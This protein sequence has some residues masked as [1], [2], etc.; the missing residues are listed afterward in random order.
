[1]PLLTLNS[2]HLYV[3][4][5]GPA[6]APVL[7]YLH[8]GP[9]TGCYDFMHQQRE[10]LGGPTRLIALD[11]RGVLRSEP[12]GEQ[13]RLTIDDLLSD[14]EALRELLH[15]E[16]WSVLGHSFGGYLALQYALAFPQ[17]VERLLFENP[18]FDFTLSIRSLLTTASTLFTKD[19]QSDLAAQCHQTIA[20]PSFT[21]EMMQSFFH[22]MSELGD[23]HTALY[24]HRSEKK[25]F[26]T[27]VA[28]SDL[29]A[30]NWRRAQR[31]S[32][33]L[34]A[35]GRLTQE[36]L[37]PRLQELTCPTLL[38]QGAYDAVTGPEQSAAFH[39]YVP[40]GTIQTFPHSSHFIHLEEPDAFASAVLSFLL[41][42]KPV[43]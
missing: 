23:R 25:H 22:L 8:G 36:S 14:L 13:E 5:A 4:E 15:I 28:N 1:M 32:Q 29:P 24:E 27:L 34:F 10:R 35:E 31:H 20:T 40:N 12:L 17:S 33:Q 11:Q 6:D 16:R 41:K 42:V 37:L 39:E 19:G 3:E 21:D 26:D 38:L 9:G 30:E 43:H 7:L 18:T 2:R